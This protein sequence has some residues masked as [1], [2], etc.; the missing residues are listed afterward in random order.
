MKIDLPL[1]EYNIQVLIRSPKGECLKT[2]DSSH[3]LVEI[4]LPD[5]VL[6]DDI[7]VQ[8]CHLDD[9]GQPMGE[10]RYL[11]EALLSEPEPKEEKD[12]DAPVECEEEAAKSPL[13]E[14]AE[15]F[16]EKEVEVKE[17]RGPKIALDD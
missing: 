11:K 13:A 2:L 8:Y 17:H 12:E 14:K 6:E 3:T 7:E 1:S 16:S 10:P 4:D 15:E 9:T 5:D